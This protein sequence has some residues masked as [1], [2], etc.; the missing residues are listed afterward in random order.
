MAKSLLLVE[1]KPASPDLVDEYNQWHEQTHIPEML[2][3]EGF[4]S[5]RRW[6]ADEGGTFL[7]LYEIDTDIETAR[8]NLR[9]VLQSGKIS[10]PEVVDTNPP[11]AMRYFTLISEATT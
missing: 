3:V 9:A 5:A 4:V 11:P 8:A 7:T 2:G 10:R 1:S 6:Q